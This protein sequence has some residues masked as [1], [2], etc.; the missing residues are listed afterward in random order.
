MLCAF[1]YFELVGYVHLFVIGAMS[2]IR[3]RIL[4][5]SWH[6]E[7]MSF[8]LDAFLRLKSGLETNECCVRCGICHRLAADVLV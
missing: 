6:R 2:E 5:C 4:T 3:S 1:M 8:V 7:F